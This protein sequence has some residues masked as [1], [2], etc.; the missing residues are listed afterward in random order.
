MW[1]DISLVGFGFFGL[2]NVRCSV[3]L[4]LLRLS[5]IFVFCFC[6]CTER[7]WLR[8]QLTGPLDTDTPVATA[9][10][11]RAYISSFLLCL[12]GFLTAPLLSAG[13][14]G[15]LKQRSLMDGSLGS[16]TGQTLRF[17]TDPAA[18]RGVVPCAGSRAHGVS[19]ELYAGSTYN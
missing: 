8:P 17:D 19:S 9:L 5:F 16:F 7:I 10:Y 12:S 14:S 1:M 15:V 6:F 3:Y 18:G 2:V 4:A 13:W 11:S